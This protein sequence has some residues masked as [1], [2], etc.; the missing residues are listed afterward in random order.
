MRST[1]CGSESISSSPTPSS[2]TTATATKTPTELE[3]QLFSLANLILCSLPVR[4]TSPIQ[5]GRAVVKPCVTSTSTQVV[6]LTP[7]FPTSGP[8]PTAVIWVVPSAGSGIP[9]RLPPARFSVTHSSITFT[10]NT[11]SSGILYWLVF[12]KPLCR[13]ELDVMVSKVMSSPPTDAATKSITSTPLVQEMVRTNS[14]NDM[15]TSGQT[16]LHAAS[17][18]GNTYLIKWLL[19]HGA[20]VNAVDNH[21]GTPLLVA[22]SSGQLESVL[23]LLKAGAEPTAH[24]DSGTNTLFY[25][26]RMKTVEDQPLYNNIFDL[27]V[28][29]R[30][31]FA[32]E[33]NFIGA[34]PLTTALTARNQL[35]TTNL[36]SLGPVIDSLNTISICGSS[37]LL[38]ALQSR[39]DPDIIRKLIQCGA[40]PNVQTTEGA[41]AVDVASE[42][43]YPTAIIELLAT[44]ILNIPVELVVQILFSLPPED[45][46]RIRRVCKSLL[47]LS[48]SI[49][50]NDDYWKIQCT[51]KEKFLASRAFEYKHILLYKELE[52]L[53]RL[54]LKPF[55]TPNAEYHKLLKILVIGDTGVGKTSLV[56]RWGE[57]SSES[58]PIIPL[59]FKLRS[60]QICG[61]IA[62]AQIWDI[63]TPQRF[64][65]Q[66]PPYRGC[67]AI[68]IVFDITNPTSLRNAKLWLQEVDRYA[69]ETVTIM[70]LGNKSDLAPV[71]TPQDIQTH[72]GD[73]LDDSNSPF[74]TR[75]VFT[76]SAKEATN[77][78]LVL[79]RL[80]QTL[81][82]KLEPTIRVIP[83]SKPP[84][85]EKNC[86]LM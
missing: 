80:V 45:L 25:L 19:S 24:T 17:N 72:L 53:K 57:G 33:T 83:I 3:N 79:Y 58:A 60:M 74:G 69:S 44:H 42:L 86:S 46:F 41:T 67:H 61:K 12:S 18:S 47:K 32:A 49:L 34:S 77:V 52:V 9:Y 15:D 7:P 16:L 30:E 14:I 50:A 75:E 10:L 35:A 37:I 2:S 29:G 23:L 78:D 82:I 64:R 39:A 13:S 6:Q 40:D 31:T 84:K 43:H 36:L 38:H 4:T 21:G 62:K 85:D 55:E 65:T 73:Y 11:D 56:T 51:T 63:P 27:L 5:T 48:R 54:P 1:L 22:S 71:V 81:L 8:I 76:T 20:N 28:R 68:I 66:R 26:C 59:D 70:F